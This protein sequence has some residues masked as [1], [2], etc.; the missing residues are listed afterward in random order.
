MFFSGFSNLTGYKKETI[1]K[2]LFNENNITMGD[3]DKKP[4][5]IS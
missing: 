1:S 4:I 5:E 3:N 2:H